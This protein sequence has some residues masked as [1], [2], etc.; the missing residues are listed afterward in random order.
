MEGS[1]HG[2]ILRYCPAICLVGL[3]KTTIN[4]SKDSRSPD[5][6]LNPR[7]LVYQ[8]GVLTTRPRHLVCRYEEKYSHETSVSTRLNI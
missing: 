1:D 3:R 5:R 2:L 8:A 6:Y 7:P 4:L